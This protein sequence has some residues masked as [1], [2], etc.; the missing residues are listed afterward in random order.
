M[1]AVIM[2]GGK[3]TRL[4]SV[5]ADIPKP[6][7]PL[8]GKPV[9]EYQIESLQKSNITEITIIVGHLG[10]VIQ[11]YFG[12]GRPWN[13]EIDYIV[14]EK[15]LGTAG[16][17]Y[18]LKETIKE[19]FFLIFG[20]LVLDV[21][22][23]RFMGFHRQKGARI[24]LYSHPNAH[25]FDSDVI[26]AD[27]TGR[28]TKIEAKNTE[29]IFYYHNLVNAGLYCISP[30]MFD[31]MFHLEKLD[32]EKN[33]VM[34]QISQS[35]VYAY[36]STEYVKDMGTPERL[37][38][39]AND[40]KNGVVSGRNLRN[41]QRC[42]FLDRDGTLNQLNGFIN[43]A[44]QLE[45]LPT[46]AKA[47]KKINAS[48]YLAIVATN[49][50]VVARGECTF[51]ELDRIHQKLET[52]LGCQGAYLDDLFFCPHH[53]H[54][55]YEGEVAEL[56]VECECRKPKIGMIL[57]AAEKYN[58]DLGSSWYIGDMTTDILT[59]INAGMRTV[60]VKTGEAGTDGKHKVKADYV[61]DDLESAVD[62]IL[63]SR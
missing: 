17:I 2:A 35:V 40:I 63:N 62:Y 45:L 9:L 52:D 37:D 24:T 25:P 26:V 29:R 13:V 39:V 46:A 21:D 34:P 60:L 61:A 30:Q 28:V 8:L 41:R 57:Q 7:V 49:Q 55:G 42:I 54:K 3:G 5:A 56:K 27:E 6:M 32:L 1:R 44:E 43:R 12:D 11:S 18:Y 16:A 59:G 10:N 14:E 4:Q 48:S 38:A 15:P 22:W 36:R 31:T 53:P 47:V 20:D 51:A 23:N 50:P 19:D 33:L 58:I